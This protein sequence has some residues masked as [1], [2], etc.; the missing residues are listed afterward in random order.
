VQNRLS[1]HLFG[2]VLV[3]YSVVGSAWLGTLVC[4]RQ[5]TPMPM[6]VLGTDAPMRAFSQSRGTC[7]SSRVIVAFLQL[8]MVVWGLLRPGL[9][10][11]M[12]PGHHCAGPHAGKGMSLTDVCVITYWKLWPR[13]LSQKPSLARLLLVSLCTVH[14][15]EARRKV[16]R[17][18]H[19]GNADTQTRGRI[20]DSHC[21]FRTLNRKKKKPNSVQS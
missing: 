5:P 19:V 2:S 16:R 15:D 8:F 12:T 4:Q 1:L 20:D 6:S 11:R 17:E 13:P 3:Q 14:R 9:P 7:C 18:Q 21:R 10:S